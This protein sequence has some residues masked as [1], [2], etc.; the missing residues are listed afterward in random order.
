[1]NVYG[2]EIIALI[3]TGAEAN[4]INHNIQLPNDVKIKNKIIS[5]STINK[6]KV[7]GR[8]CVD[9]TINVDG[10]QVTDEFYIIDQ[11]ET[12]IIGKYLMHKI[13]YKITIP[14]IINENNSNNDIQIYDGEDKNVERSS[15]V[16]IIKVNEDICVNDYVKY[17]PENISDIKIH[18]IETLIQNIDEHLRDDVSEIIRELFIKYECTVP[19]SEFDIGTYKKRKYKIELKNNYDNKGCSKSLGPLLCS[20]V[21]ELLHHFFFLITQK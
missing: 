1:M 17:Y 2:N 18:Q 14:N 11:A 16:N 12:M 6:N 9:L 21:V 15:M 19:E 8:E 5:F 13:G 10:K 4:I 7:K 3:D 20:C